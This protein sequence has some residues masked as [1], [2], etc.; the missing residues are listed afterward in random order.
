MRFDVLVVLV[1]AILI[2]A[3]YM[4]TSGLY[5]SKAIELTQRIYWAITQQLP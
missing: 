3:D 4:F 5:T 2:L 1:I